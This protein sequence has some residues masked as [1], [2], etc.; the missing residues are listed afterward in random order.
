MTWYW[1][2]HLVSEKKNQKQSHRA[3]QANFEY[4]RSVQGPSQEV[5]HPYNITK[6]MKK[7]NYSIN[8]MIIFG[9]AT[10]AIT[11]STELTQLLSASASIFSGWSGNGQQD[12]QLLHL[13][14]PREQQKKT[15]NHFT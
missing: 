1:N 6:M 11:S 12:Q 2:L 8:P 14:Q 9:C 7:K 10:H 5:P 3:L 4:Y 15:L 13:L